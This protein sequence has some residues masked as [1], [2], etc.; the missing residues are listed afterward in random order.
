MTL[1][2]IEIKI[3]EQARFEADAIK[4]EA[5]ESQAKYVKNHEERIAEIEQTARKQARAKADAAKR[6][7]L[8]PARLAAR[9]KVLEAKQALLSGLYSEVKKEKKLSEAELNDL[10]E[11][12]EVKAA[13][14]LFNEK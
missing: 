9:Q 1:K 12:S 13:A 6:S 14:V 5:R 7:I 4:A 3:L 2:D 8:V 10:R 11:A